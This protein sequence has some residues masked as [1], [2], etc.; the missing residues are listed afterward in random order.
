[1]IRLKDILK[2][3][4][5]IITMDVD[6]NILILQRYNTSIITELISF[7]QYLINRLD[8][9][10]YHGDNISLIEVSSLLPCEVWSVAITILSKAC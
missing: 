6:K 9:E 7:L 10:L 2:L 1:M 3:C 5:T 8:K 4:L